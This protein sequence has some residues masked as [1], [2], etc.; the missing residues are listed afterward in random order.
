M[1][2]LEQGAMPARVVAVARVREQRRV[3]GD[4][5]VDEEEQLREEVGDVRVRVRGVRARRRR[6]RARVAVR[7]R[8]LVSNRAPRGFQIAARAPRRLRRE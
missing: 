4:A 6:R 5:R 1:R 2:A 7:R 8:P 3:R